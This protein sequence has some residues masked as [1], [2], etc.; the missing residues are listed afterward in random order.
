MGKNLDDLAREVINGTWSNG[1]EH[2]AH[3][4]ATGYNYDMVQSRVNAKLGYSFVL[5]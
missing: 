2:H 5:Q 1:E 3:L 4:N